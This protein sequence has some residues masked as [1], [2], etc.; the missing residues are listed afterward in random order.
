MRTLLQG[1]PLDPE[2]ELEPYRRRETSLALV[3]LAVIA[4]LF[5]MHISFIAYLGPPKPLL[6]SVLASMFVLQSSGLFWVQGLQRLPSARAVWA[7]SAVSIWATVLG[8]FLASFFG[9][10]EEH[11]Y[12][13]LMVPAIVSAGF[14]LSLSGTLFVVAV[15]GGMLFFDVFL[16]FHRHPPAQVMELFEAGVIWIVF[17]VLGVVVWLLA[18]SSRRGRGRL[19]KSLDELE[20]TRD[21][22]VAEEKLAA[23]GRL[24][25]AIAHEIRNPVAMIS[26]S[27]AAARR[28]GLPEDQRRQ[29]FDVAT[30]EASR[31][32]RLTTDFLAYARTRMPERKP[33]ALAET[34][35]YVAELARARAGER[36]VAIVAEDAAGLCGSIDPHQMHQALLNLVTNAI[37]HTPEGGRVSLGA[38]AGEPERVLLWVENSG[39]AIPEAALTRIFEPFFTTRAGGTGLGLAIASN[40]ARAHGGELRLGANV[41]GRVRFEIVLPRCTD[42]ARRNQKDICPIS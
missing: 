4:A 38:A 8:A 26:S 35:G 23:V 22:L 30:A 1:R 39:P 40:I 34:L 25:S 36:R 3:N 14:R 9:E 15:S 13:V 32:E 24:S 27:L 21:R 16:W 33:T 6:V 2:P 5:L 31:L 28:P 7:Y 12:F 37:E 18:E 42:C 41:P 11:H 10:G 29:M 20:R 17:A 19:R